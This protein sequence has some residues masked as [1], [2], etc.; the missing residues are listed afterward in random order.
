MKKFISYHPTELFFGDGSLDSLGEIVSQLGQRALLIRTPLIEPMRSTYERV[1]ML[2]RAAN[3][4][5][6]CFDDVEPNP[7]TSVIN[8]AA[9][10]AKAANVDVIIALGGGSSIDTAKAVAIEAAYNKPCWDFRFGSGL[11]PG[12]ETLPIIAIPTTSGTGSEVTPV[13]VV[14]NEEENYKSII[15]SKNIF[16]KAAIM[17]PSLTYSMPKQLTAETGFD[18]FAHCF[19]SYISSNATLTSSIY[20]LEG[21]RLVAK[22]LLVA[23][24]QPDNREA[25][26][27]MMMA[28]TMGGMAIA[29]TGVTLPHGMGMAIGGYCHQMSH[30]ASMAMVYPDIIEQSVVEGGERYANVARLFKPSLGD[31][32]AQHLPRIITEFLQ[33]L[34]LGKSLSDYGIK[35]DMLPDIAKASVEQPGWQEHP[36]VHS[37]AE[38]LNI[39]ER[40][41]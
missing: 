27:D 19:E 35:K 8:K 24:Q 34:N 29:E 9:L 11:E 31:D 18:A 2:I 1:E 26:A 12:V 32:A 4:E 20:A 14:S 16:C 22:S 23:F 28:A 25:R 13:A 36:K 38:M 39:L 33:R 37:Q 3:V 40:S 6:H 5:L 17:E 7:T 10:Q 15:W 21:M 41:F 30:G